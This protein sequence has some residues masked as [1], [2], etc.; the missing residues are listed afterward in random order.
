MANLMNK[1]IFNRIRELVSPPLEIGSGTGLLS[2]DEMACV[3]ALLRT[4]TADPD[5]PTER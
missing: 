4:L 1:S 5:F 3:V 2:D